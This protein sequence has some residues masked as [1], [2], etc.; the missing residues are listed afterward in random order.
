M[1][2]GAKDWRT[3]AWD[4]LLSSTGKKKKK[5]TRVKRRGGEKES[6]GEK[7]RRFDNKSF[8][9]GEVSLRYGGLWREC[10]RRKLRGLQASGVAVASSRP[11]ED[12]LRVKCLDGTQG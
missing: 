5:S 2:L 1:F 4:C 3:Q 12:V 9:D 6:G 8:L 11:L 7:K 10:D